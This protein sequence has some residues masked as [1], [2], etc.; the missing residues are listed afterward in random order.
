[1]FA[2][3]GIAT[4]LSGSLV[5]HGEVPVSQ[6]AAQNT[7][8]VERPLTYH[9]NG[10]LGTPVRMNDKVDLEF[11][12]DTGATLSGIWNS[13]IQQNSLKYNHISNA[14]IGAADGMV[15]LRMLQ[16]RSMNVSALS[17]KP[18]VLT[19]FPDYYAYYRRPLSG[20]LGAD[21]LQNYL[22]VFDFPREKI[23]FY[24]KNTNLTRKMPGYFDVV[25][26]TYSRQFNALLMQVKVNDKKVNALLDTGAAMTTMLE[27]EAARLGISTEG[28]PRTI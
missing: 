15:V 19:E 4:L 5:A 24:P 18:A 11:I 20:I 1:M 25:P 6:S 26:L 17:L 13:A 27:T 14:N 2:L 22:V 7:L 8:V 10:A 21:F 3:S 23:V 16:F 28:A 12:I 9:N